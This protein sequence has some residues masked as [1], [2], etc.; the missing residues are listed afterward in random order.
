[1]LQR[2]ALTWVKQK[3][4]RAPEMTPPDQETSYLKQLFL[5]TG[6]KL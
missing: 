3:Q 1:L 4:P 6:Y 5:R 2:S